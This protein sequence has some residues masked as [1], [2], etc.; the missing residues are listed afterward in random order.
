MPIKPESLAHIAVVR[1]T[2][3]GDVRSA[4][5]HSLTLTEIGICF[6]MFLLHGNKVNRCASG[7]ADG[8]NILSLISSCCFT[9]GLP[10][11]LM[12]VV[13]LI[14]RPVPRRGRPYMGTSLENV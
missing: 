12:L 11:Q 9:H 7:G 10:H 1:L 2:T 4:H 6:V 3:W 13:T 14:P 5:W 8:S